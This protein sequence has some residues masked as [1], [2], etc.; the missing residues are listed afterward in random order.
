M[1]FHG[2]I[3]NAICDLILENHRYTHIYQNSFYWCFVVYR[4]HRNG[5]TKFQLYEL[6]S[7]GNTAVE[8]QTSEYI[9]M[10]R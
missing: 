3:I 4:G 7:V 2:M 8:S 6:S 5:L 1:L 9:N 10:H